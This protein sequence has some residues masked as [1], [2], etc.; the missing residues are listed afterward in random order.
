[1]CIR[2]GRDQVRL[3]LLDPIAVVIVL[4]TG[5]AAVTVGY[6]RQLVFAVVGVGGAVDG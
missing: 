6:L 2:A 1:M 3:G 4:I 5:G